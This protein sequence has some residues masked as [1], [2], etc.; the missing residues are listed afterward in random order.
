MSMKSDTNVVDRPAAVQPLEERRLLAGFDTSF[1][2]QPKGTAPSG[3][4]ADTGGEYSE[5]NGL[6]YG[7]D[8]DNSKFVHDRHTKAINR[9]DKLAF[10][11]IGNSATQWEVEVP[12]G[13]YRVK[14]LAGDARFT[15]SRYA[16]DVEDRTVL[17]RAPNKASKWRKGE[18]LVYVA[19]GKL[20]V[21]SASNAINN[22][23][24]SI[25]IQQVDPHVTGNDIVNPFSMNAIQNNEM[26]YGLAEPLLDDLGTK[27]VK[28]IYD[29]EDW[30]EDVRTWDVKNL[31]KYKKAGYST[32]VLFFTEKVPTV[33]Q[34]TAFWQRLV[35][36]P[37]FT[38]VVDFWQ[39]GNEPNITRFWE[40]TTQQ[41]ITRLMQPAYEV[42]HPLG[43]VVVGTPASFD[44]GYAQQ[45][46]SFGYSDY[47]D[48]AG[49]HPYGFNA[50]QVIDR[51]AG[52]K[53]AFGGMPIIASEWSIDMN[54]QSDSSW[55][56]AL[57]TA[58]AGI[59]DVGYLNFYYALGTGTSRVGPA[60]VFDFLTQERNGEFY[61]V[62]KDSMI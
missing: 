57:E 3:Y 61:D 47:C 16:F 2:F 5:K 44:V 32:F 4:I 62:I 53:A 46:E 20:T 7:W 12:N 48:Y 58:I 8:K 60:G 9:Y 18:G 13:L 24:N 56:A 34:A 36:H 42:L 38:D 35:D 11:G 15:N 25:N 22:K 30:N 31:A 39:P 19:D 37:G 1:N 51:L 40:G 33:Q 28:V 49:F 6:T 14:I 21:T 43:E 52:A 10:M 45:L 26:A 27:V 23:I 54:G 41:V 55:A 17:N 29:V 59:R 50:Q